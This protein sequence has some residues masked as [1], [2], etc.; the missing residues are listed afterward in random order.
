MRT[1]SSHHPITLALTVGLA[2]AIPASAVYVIYL[3]LGDMTGQDKTFFRG[4][5][6]TL[7]AFLSVVLILSLFLSV[8]VRAT[9][10]NQIDI[11]AL[12]AD[13]YN[14]SK[15]TT[16]HHYPEQGQLGGHGYPALPTPSYPITSFFGEP[17]ARDE[18]AND[19]VLQ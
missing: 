16:H 5:A 4:A 8:F 14:A 1:Q 19:I 2:L 15:V 13:R 6:F 17:A 3:L 9:L 18:Q 11:D 7:F 10:R 12:R